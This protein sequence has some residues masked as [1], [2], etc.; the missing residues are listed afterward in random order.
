[1]GVGASRVRDL[2]EKVS[3]VLSEGLLRARLA[4]TAAVKSVAAQVFAAFQV[5]VACSSIVV[6]G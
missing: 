3:T 4:S 1:M 5:P 2:F 6:V